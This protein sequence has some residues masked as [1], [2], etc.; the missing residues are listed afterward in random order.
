[1]TKILTPLVL[2]YAGT[3]DEEAWDLVGDFLVYSPILEPHLS[4]GILTVPS[5]FR[6]DLAS[7]PR[8]PLMYWLTGGKGKLGSVPHDYLCETK[9]VSREVADKLFLA[10]METSHVPVWRRKLMYGAVRTY[11]IVSGKDS[12]YKRVPVDAQDTYFG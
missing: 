6:T 10:I 9:L 12:E 5:G 1:M 3:N 8:L 7:V 2:R 4:C 11:A